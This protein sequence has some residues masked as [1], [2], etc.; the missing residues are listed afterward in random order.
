[1]VVEDAHR[2]IS[3]SHPVSELIR[4]CILQKAEFRILA[5]TDCK[6]DKVGELQLIVMNLQIDLIRSLSSIRE[7]ISLTFA[8][9]KMCKLYINISD[10]IRHIGNE[11]LKTMEPIASLLYESGIF[12]TND[13]KKIAN[14]SINYLQRKM[15]IGQDHLTEIYCDF[16]ELLSAYDI[17]MCDGLTAFRNTLQALCS[18]SRTIAE[19]TQSNDILRKTCFLSTPLRSDNLQCHKLDMLI[20]LLTK[21]STYYRSKKSIVVLL[22]RDRDPAF[23]NSL[24]LSVTARLSDKESGFAFFLVKSNTFA[25]F[26]K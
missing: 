24:L 6:L 16:F 4:N 19:I 1:M 12:P 17:L 22:C 14:F 11:L 20:T 8:S 26:Y 13:I 15:Q 21:T 2:A 7:E 3:G 10:D 25:L 9:P 18:K 5:Y 23:F